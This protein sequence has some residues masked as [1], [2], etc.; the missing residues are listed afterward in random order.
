VAP[1]GRATLA[2]TLACCWLTSQGQ[3]GRAIALKGSCAA[4]ATTA[5]LLK[6][7]RLWRQ[8]PAAAV[9]PWRRSLLSLKPIARL[10]VMP[11]F[12][13]RTPVDTARGKRCA[14]QTFGRQ[15]PRAR[16]ACLLA[17]LSARALLFLDPAPRRTPPQAV[18]RES[19]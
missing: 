6:T 7:A 10:R 13:S 17:C 2:H 16:V 12:L 15:A 3:V 8:G 14:F 19:F 4:P 1:I 18:R 9:A 11:L 5:M